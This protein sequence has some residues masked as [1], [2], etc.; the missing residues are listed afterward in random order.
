M[1]QCHLASTEG[2]YAYVQQIQ[3]ICS[4]LTDHAYCRIKAL[5]KRGHSSL[6]QCCSRLMLDPCDEDHQLSWCPAGLLPPP[7]LPHHMDS[8]AEDFQDKGNFRPSK[9]RAPLRPIRWSQQQRSQD[10]W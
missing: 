2:A 5:E 4:A 8:Q 6:T 1:P 10:Q 3:A 7:G 9:L